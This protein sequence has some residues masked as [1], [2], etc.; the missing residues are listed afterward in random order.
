MD[1]N[2]IDFKKFLKAALKVRF[3]GISPYDFED[4]LSKLFR[5]NA[6]TISPTKYAGDYG[7]DLILEKDGLVTVVQ[8]KRYH[9]DHKVGVQDVNQVIGAAK[10][11]KADQ[12]MIVTTSALTEPAMELCRKANVYVWDW[13]ILK[14]AIYRTYDLDDEW[15][16]DISTDNPEASDDYFE[17]YVLEV[18]PDQYV[19]DSPVPR[20]K[21]VMEMHNKSG[22]NVNVFLDLPILLRHNNKQYNSVDWAQN[23]F[24]SG[25]IYNGAEVEVACYYLEENLSEIQKGDQVLIPVSAPALSLLKTYTTPLSPED[26]RCFL[27]TYAFD[28]YSPM[29][30]DAVRFRDRI[31]SKYRVGRWWIRFYYNWSPVFINTFGHLP[32]FRFFLKKIIKLIMSVRLKRY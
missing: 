10:Y 16:F 9:Q 7:A 5:D 27:V 17:F 18:S 22:R 31:L 14:G 20:T 23:Y 4:F 24:K 3:Q 2:Q 8:V 25:I 6:Y 28:K 1:F 12:I 19:E 21:V 26:T 13:D 15:L 30:F 32:L 11:Y 29:Y